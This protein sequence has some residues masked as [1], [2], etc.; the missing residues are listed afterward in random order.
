MK[1][2]RLVALVIGMLYFQISMASDVIV[3]DK[4]NDNTLNISRSIK[5]YIDESGTESIETIKNKEFLPVQGEFLHVETSRSAV[6]IKFKIVNKS[7][8]HRLLL[9]VEQPMLDVVE[10]YGK[11][12]HKVISQHLP[13][14]DREFNNPNSIF[15]LKLLPGDTTEYLLKLTVYKDVQIP[16]YVGTSVSLYDHLRYKDTIM[17]IYLGILL[18]M[19][20]YNLFIF[21]SVRDINYLYYVI[22]LLLVFFTQVAPYGYT[23]QYVWP[24]YPWFERNAMFILPALVGIAGLEFFKRFVHLRTLAPKLNLITWV[25]ILIYISGMML[26]LTGHYAAGYRIIQINAILVSLFILSVCVLALRSGYKPAM[27]FLIAWGVFLVGI[28]IFVMKDLGTLPANNFTNYTMQ[29]GSGIEVVLLSF[30]LANKINDLKRE[31]EASQ[32][33][34]LKISKENEKIIREQNQVL[35]LKVKERT[36]KLE[37]ANEEIKSTYNNLKETQA[38]LVNSEK[39]ASLGQLTAG[40]AHEI[41]NPI[42]FISSNVKPLRRDIEDLINALSVY[43]KEIIG[44]GNEDVIKRLQRFKKEI[45]LDYLTSEMNSLLEGIDEGASRTAEIIRAL[46]NFSRLDQAELKNAN[47]NDGLESTLKILNNQIKDRIMVVRNYDDLP[48]IECYP[49]KLNQVFLNIINNAVQAIEERWEKPEEGI[50]TLSTQNLNHQIVVTIE[51]NGSG[52]PEEVKKKIFEPFFTTKDVGKGTG[53]GLS[54]VYSI[55]EDHDGEIYVESEK[56]IGTKFI[57]KI[58]KRGDSV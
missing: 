12:Y 45:D 40:I 44:L 49:G 36:S 48:E 32:A 14:N 33:E 23:F 55:I 24:D 42:N 16:F 47:L 41:N 27:F 46:K 34:A 3:F 2:T 18:V 56:G 58:P 7:S 8:F 29:F 19:F 20:V 6:W 52:M 54:I 11:D 17:A 39:M 50:L 25:F 4:K 38:K 21:L 51:D 28:I 43:E 5:Y 53:L 22:Y 9:L 26:A 10:F 13:F 31:K 57:I 35:E 30:G 37:E 15:D 1:F